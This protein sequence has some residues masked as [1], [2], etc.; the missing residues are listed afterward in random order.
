MSKNMPNAGD[1]MEHTIEYYK[2]E[3]RK[4]VIPELEVTSLAD[5]INFT[6][7]AKE[8][9]R[10]ALFR[11][12][13]DKEWEIESSAY[14][15]LKANF[16]VPT[17][18]MM[19]DYHT[20][21]IREFRQLGE[22]IE[23]KGVSLI[24]HL[25]HNGAKTFLLDYTK[26]P[27]VALWFACISEKEKD[28]GVYMAKTGVGTDEW[29][30]LDGD[31]EIADLF[32][33]KD[34]TYQYEPAKINR[35]IICQQSVFLVSLSGKIEKSKHITVVIPKKHK[36]EILS[37]LSAVG[38]SRS[39]LFPDFYGLVEWF[40]IEWFSFN[41]EAEK[42]DYDKLMSSG[43]KYTDQF[44][45]EEAVT[46]FEEAA[47]LAQSLFG[48]NSAETAAS[49]GSLGNVYDD[50]GK[51]DQALEWFEKA[52]AIRE[53]VLGKEHPDT[54]STYNNIALVYDDQGKYDQALEWFEKA[55]AIAEKVLGKEHPDT[56]STYNNIA[57]VYYRQ[58]EYDKALEWFEKALAIFEK[59][60]GKEHPDTATTYNNVASVYDNQGKYDQALEWY[61]KA[62]N[63]YE[64][65]LGKNHPS[66]VLTR[67]NMERTIKKMDGAP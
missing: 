17:Q 56:A 39:V 28:A 2:E 27:L 10:R 16:K 48:E 12:Q 24:A 50:Q 9:Y 25:Q 23:Y 15:A 36:D 29:I 52:L 31:I 14:R 30:P 65:V 61:E 8:S 64:K 66:T 41:K 37:Q 45:F 3:I 22:N 34:I 60:L 26:N 7:A 59:T 35:R 13:A 47:G 57:S 4:P 54:A 46:V 20:D 38:I 6:V 67:E 21:L 33:K 5:Y 53:K 55:L 49:Y 1:F 51:Y 19:R 63:I 58:G 43:A 62:L 40:S 18:K 44:K 11:G 32:A 42:E